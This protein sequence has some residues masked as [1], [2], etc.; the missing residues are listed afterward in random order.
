MP[1]RTSCTDSVWHQP[2]CG[3]QPYS[4][5]IIHKFLHQSAGKSKSWQAWHRMCACFFCASATFV[6]VDC[7]SIRLMASMRRTTYC[8]RIYNWSK[9]W[10]SVPPRLSTSGIITAYMTSDLYCGGATTPCWPKFFLLHHH[11]SHQTSIQ[12]INSLFPLLIDGLLLHYFFL[13]S[14]PTQSDQLKKKFTGVQWVQTAASVSLMAAAPSTE[15][16]GAVSAV[17]LREP[18]LVARGPV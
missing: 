17:W 12:S 16:V 10:L 3:Q 15:V 7:S 6:V 1:T 8:F 18:R 5:M 14:C 11:R 2:C 9:T 13:Y 4:L